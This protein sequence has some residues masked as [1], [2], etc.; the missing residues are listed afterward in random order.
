MAQ[1]PARSLLSSQ[2]ENAIFNIQ[3]WKP[4]RD[5]PH[6]QGWPRRCDVSLFTRVA[7]A[8]TINAPCNRRLNL[9]VFPKGQ[10]Q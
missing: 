7:D 9:Q 3:Y 1:R 5:Y 10:V 2:V 8:R 6:R 4:G